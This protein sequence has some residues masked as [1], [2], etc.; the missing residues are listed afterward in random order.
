LEG[1]GRKVTVAW[2]RKIT[3][4]LQFIRP[5]IL[6]TLR[7]SLLWRQ[8]DDDSQNKFTQI[9]NC[10]EILSYIINRMIQLEEIK[11][12]AFYWVEFHI[13]ILNQFAEQ[14][15]WTSLYTKALQNNPHWQSLMWYDLWW[16]LF[17]FNSGTKYFYILLIIIVPFLPCHG[18]RYF[19]YRN[20]HVD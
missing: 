19:F 20:L 2:I 3:R 1:S 7:C 9:N 18:K 16:V 12:K 15:K 14:R 5:A 11:T 17:Q 6:E 4:I 13:S 8:S 10:N